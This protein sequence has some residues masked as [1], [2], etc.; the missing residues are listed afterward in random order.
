MSRWQPTYTRAPMAVAGPGCFWLP[1]SLSSASGVALWPEV[2]EV[3]I[4]YLAPLGL[5]LQADIA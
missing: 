3:P 5:K 1:E 2:L 4:R